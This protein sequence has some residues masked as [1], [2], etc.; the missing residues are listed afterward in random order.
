MI[1][2]KQNIAVLLAAYDGEKYIR[3][4]LD[5]ILN[6]INVD[7]SIFISVDKSS[8]YSLSIVQEYAKLFPKIVTILPYGI[9][10]G[11]AAKNFFRL[12]MEVDLSQYDY[13]ALSDQDDIWE[14][15]KLS[16][17]IKEICKYKSS[18]L[19]S[20]V[21]AFWPD[22][23]EKILRKNY[24]QTKYD[25]LFES[26]GPG[27]TFILKYDLVSQ[28]KLDLIKNKAKLD[29]I[30]MHD[31]FIY[32]YA[33]QKGFK[34]VIDKNPL[35]RYRQHASNEVG[36]RSG[37]HPFIYRVRK[38]LNVSGIDN[39][40]KQ[41]RFLEQ[42]ELEPIKLLLKGDFISHMKLLILSRFCRRKL[43]D[44]F[45]IFFAFILLYA[46]KNIK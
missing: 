30:W 40:L 46:K 33:R 24:P 10:Y 17:G 38:I 9:K 39:V 2:R 27:C 8:D 4:Q 28:L 22:G 19:S 31:W 1:N 14:S 15:D 37:W 20:D 6:Q 43:T 12:I 3:T 5:S 36:A 11:S 7:V 29:L 23:K 18:A 25:Y 34:W 21:I 26:A 42:T 32:S 16:H 45:F 35:I 41:S 13:V 44:K